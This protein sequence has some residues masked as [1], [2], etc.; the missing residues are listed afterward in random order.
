[1]TSLEICIDNLESLFT[2]QE[3]APIASSSALRWGWVA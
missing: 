1:M 2:A 3:L